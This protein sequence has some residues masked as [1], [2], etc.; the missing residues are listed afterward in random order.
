MYESSSRATARRVAPTVLC[1]ASR[2]SPSGALTRS[3]TSQHPLRRR[4]ATPQ[5]A[6]RRELQRDWFGHSMFPCD[7][8]SIVP[9]LPRCILRPSGIAMVKPPCLSS[10]F[11]CLSNRASG[12]ETKRARA[13]SCDGRAGEL[14]TCLPRTSRTRKRVQN[15]EY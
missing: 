10:P 12:S 13:Q 4:V 2:C 3:L 6:P 7:R 8:R 5:L 14:V 1:P 15:A 9:A 11:F